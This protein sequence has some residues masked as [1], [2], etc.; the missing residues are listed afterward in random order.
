VTQE[1]LTEKASITAFT[2]EEESFY[3][4]E[5]LLIVAHGTVPAHLMRS[6]DRLEQGTVSNQ[7]DHTTTSS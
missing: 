2:P 4:L 5:A 3:E 6:K 1:D 7:I